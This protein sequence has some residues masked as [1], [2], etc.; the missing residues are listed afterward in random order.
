[1]ARNAKAGRGRNG[2]NGAVLGF[3]AKLWQ[4]A[5]KLRNNMDS[6]EDKHVVLGLVFLKYIS[7]AF[8]ERYQELKKTPHADPEDK[9][10]YA[11]GE[12]LLGAQARPLAQHPGE[13]EGSRDRET[14]RR[15]DGRHREGEPGA[16][17]GS[18]EGLQPRGAG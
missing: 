10:E 1:M 2:P 13:G 4:A 5:D 3:E 18:P 9:D 8:R 16:E 11:R 14:N 7:D 12:C 17:G 15:C 6:A